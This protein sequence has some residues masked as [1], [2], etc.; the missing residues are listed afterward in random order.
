MHM[1]G[2][3]IMVKNKCSQSSVEAGGRESV[4]QTCF[5]ISSHS[6]DLRVCQ[7]IHL[8]NCIKFSF[9]HNKGWSE[10]SMLAVLVAF[11][12]QSSREATC[13]GPVVMKTALFTSQR[14]DLSSLV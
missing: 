12:L 9:R 14:Y 4:Y 7:C 10:I 11:S 2:I 13:Q 1:T 6:G 8:T 3:P 5:F